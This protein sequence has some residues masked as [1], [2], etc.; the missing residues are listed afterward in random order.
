MKIGGY[1]VEFGCLMGGVINVIIKSGINEFKV[2]VNF[3]Y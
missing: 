3:Y 1:L 2:G